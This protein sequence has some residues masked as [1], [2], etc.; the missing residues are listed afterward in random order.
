V[1]V[2]MRVAVRLLGARLVGVSF[3]FVHKFPPIATS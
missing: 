1:G 2:L 3:V